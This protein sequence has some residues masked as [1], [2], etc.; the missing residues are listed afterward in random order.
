M[1]HPTTETDLSPAVEKHIEELVGY[2]SKLCHKIMLKQMRAVMEEVRDIVKERNR[3]QWLL[4]QV[5]ND[6]PQKRDWL[7]P[8]IEREMREVTR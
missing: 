4:K 1:S 3:A 2:A 5:L 7:N 8:E 6:L